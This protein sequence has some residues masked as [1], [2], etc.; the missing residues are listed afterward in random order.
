MILWKSFSSQARKIKRENS[1]DIKELTK[2]LESSIQ[3]SRYKFIPWWECNPEEDMY[4]YSMFTEPEIQEAESCI[5]DCD[6]DTLTDTSGSLGMS[7]FHLL[8]WHNFYGAVK[9]I[10]DD[11]AA[12]I[13]VNMADGKGRGL[14]PLLLACCRGN[15]GMAKLLIDHGADTKHCDAAG[16]NGYHYLACPSIE[17]L[18]NGFECQRYSLDQREPIARLLAD[19][20]NAKDMNGLTPLVLMLQGQNSNRSYA[21]T[22]VFLEKGAETDYVDE[23]GNTLL[24][25]AIHNHHLTAALRLAERGDMVNTPNADG[26]TPMQAANNMRNTGLCM[27][28]KDYGSTE[29]CDAG[30]MDMANFSRITSNA[31]ASVSDEEKDNLSVALYLAKKLI[32][33]IDTDDDDDMEHLSGILYNALMNDEKCQVLDLC[34]DAGIDFT[35]PIHRRGSVFCLR[36]NCLGGNYGVKVIK[37]FIEYGIDMD[38]AVIQGKTPANIVASGT[39]R[40][41]LFSRK[42]DDYFETAAPFFSKESMEQ[43]D[44]SGVSAVHQAARNGHLEMLKIMLGKGVD[45]NI[46]QDSPAEAGNTPLHVACIYGHAE[47]VKLLEASGADSSL[48]NI[49]GE[50]P[51]HHAVMKK[52]FGGD[53]DAKKRAAVLKELKHLD[54][55]RNDGKTPLMLLQYLDINTMLELLPIFL[56]KVVDVNAADNAGN[57]ALIL[58]TKNQCYKDIV[59]EL[60]RAGADVNKTDNEGNTALYYALRYGSLDA[61]RFLIKKGA[62]YNHANNKGET[63]VQIAVEKGYDTVL[64]LMT[65]IQ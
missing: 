28:L 62:D 6:K 39:P 36:D 25:T 2:T 24:L 58:H 33:R 29:D 32:E 17:K 50:L 23:K 45:V 53:L 13:D 57:T 20:I 18:Q 56:E 60:V 59:K 26:E 43:L 49:N 27:A 1:M 52:K 35:A 5:A 14:T 41:M 30:R 61:S 3:S 10:L 22:K 11:E 42:R 15:Y 40:N 55:A 44:N 48:G 7:L 51:A 34:R 21:L 37:K 54:G 16:R 4:R 19:G 65:D 31:F 63:C 12:G 38:E 9:K 47:I 8:V 64:E 46:T